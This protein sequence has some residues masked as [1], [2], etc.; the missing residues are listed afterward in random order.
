MARNKVQSKYTA[1][2]RAFIEPLWERGISSSSIAEM[3]NAN[4]G[5]QMT[6]N[7]V[8][9][10]VRAMKLPQREQ[11]GIWRVTGAAKRMAT[12]EAN[13]TP[14]GPKKKPA[15]PEL[16]IASEAQPPIGPLDDFVAP[17]CCKWPVSATGEPW[18]QCGHPALDGRPYCAHH[19]A[20][21]Y[22]TQHRAIATTAAFRSDRI[23]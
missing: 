19:C 7:A 15:I 8:L 16:P 18:R 11:G 10:L 21:A 23:R 2:H 20:R 22:T 12:M 14:F 13:G 1:E 6:H 17:G 5:L 4:F 9:S 3:V